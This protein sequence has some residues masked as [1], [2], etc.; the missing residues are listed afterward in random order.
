MELCGGFCEPYLG[1]HA[2]RVEDLFPVSGRTERQRNK[3][4]PNLEPGLLGFAGLDASSVPRSS[5]LTHSLPYSRV[6]T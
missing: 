4:V 3:G 1:L 6:S 2:E 5:S